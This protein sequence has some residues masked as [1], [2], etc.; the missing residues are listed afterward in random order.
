MKRK[1]AKKTYFKYENVHINLQCVSF[2]FR[3]I[4]PHGESRKSK[5]QKG[6]KSRVKFF[7]RFLFSTVVVHWERNFRPENEKKVRICRWK[8]K[9]E[10]SKR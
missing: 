4:L 7:T 1:G 2:S 6:V 3:N 9:N 10:L 8:R 5:L